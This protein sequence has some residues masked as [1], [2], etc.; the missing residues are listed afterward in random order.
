MCLSDPTEGGMDGAHVSSTHEGTAYVTV[1]PPKGGV[2][3]EVVSLCACQTH[4]RRR[5]LCTCQ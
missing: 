3:S 5:G 4:K 2:A 1:S